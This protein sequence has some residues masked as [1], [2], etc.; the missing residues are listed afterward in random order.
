M[1]RA[2][3]IGLGVAGTGHLILF[4][5]LSVGFLATPNPEQLKQQPIS[6]TL[7]D[8]VALEAAAEQ[9]EVAPAQ[10]VA[11]EIA[12]P[13]DAAP[14]APSEVAEPEPAPA[15]PQPA[16]PEPAPK[17]E[18]KPAP[19]PE[20]KPEPKPKP[21]PKPAPAAKPDPKPQPRPKPTKAAAA[22]APAKAAPAAKPQA[23]PKAAPQK[24]AAKPGAGKA[25]QA[26][27]RK[28]GG[29]T[30]GDDVFKGAN[31]RPAPKSNVT[32]QA[33]TISREAL[34]GIIE[35][36]R[37]QIQPCADRQVTTGMPGASDIV[38]T[39]NLKLNRNGSLAGAPTLVSASGVNE[40]NERYRQR[41]IDLGI[42]A[43]RGCAPLEL[44]AQYYQTANGGWS[45]IN[46]RWSIR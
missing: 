35:A 26:P 17:P 21:Q 46:Y 5:L 33:A 40:G 7:A 44:P 23:A 6:I 42:A 20:P 1:E 29:L 13:E 28:P 39:L 2:E 4:G 10:S 34:S 24:P 14:P 16:P 9:S 27:R 45:N 19:K 37:R 12:P 31:D 8:D 43:F 38:V 25:E 3:K 18:P 22:P 36:I 41:V 11:P 15:P 32:A 30:L